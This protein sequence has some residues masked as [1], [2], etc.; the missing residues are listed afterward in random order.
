MTMQIPEKVEYIINILMK[1][2]QEAYAV[3]GCVRDSILGRIP[4]DWDITTSAKP[5]QVKALFR[6]TIDTGI[7]HGTVTVMLDKEGFEVTTYRIDGEYEDSRHPKNIEFTSDLEEDLK[8]RDFTINAMAYNPKEGLVD[9]FGG[10]EDLNKNVIR[11]VGN[12]KDRFSEDALR[13]LRAVRFAGQLGFAIEEKTK[14]AIVEL[15]PTLKNISAERIRVEL[16]KLLMAKYPELIKVASETGICRVVLPELDRMLGCEQ[17]NPHHIFTVGDHCIQA[18]RWLNKE[19]K[20]TPE[21]D[22]KTHSILAWTMLLHDVG[23]PDCYTEDENGIGHFYGH[24]EKSAELTKEIL[25]R[26]KFDNYTIE[27]ATRLVK[28]HDY[29]FG[30]KEA[31]MRKAANKI[32]TDMMELLFVVQRFDI[33]AQN[34]DTHEEKLKK[35]EEAKELYESICAKQHCLTLKELAVNGRDLMEAGFEK[36]KQLGEILE[37]L[38]GEVLEEPEL[39]KKEKLLELADSKFA[40][41]EGKS[42][43]IENA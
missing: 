42:D 31:S 34:P 32:G 40:K 13:I 41:A 12:A 10:M 22:K 9:I 5:E 33:L 35:L 8:R 6:R 18:V 30:E 16:D 39:N 38:L 43:K 23:K 29:R 25:K 1:N 20:N 27:T 14:D 28:W 17:N 7:Q 36:G 26:L 37:Y 2:G 11:C 21:Y 4:E 3:G 24:G 19:Y 15:A